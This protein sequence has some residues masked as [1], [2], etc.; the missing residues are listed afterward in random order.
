MTKRK[1]SKSWGTSAE[2]AFIETIA[3]KPRKLRGYFAAM[4]NHERDWGSVDRMA[5]FDAVNTAMRRLNA[6]QQGGT[7]SGVA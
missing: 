4:V 2:L 6:P 3:D 1:R 7:R 5:V